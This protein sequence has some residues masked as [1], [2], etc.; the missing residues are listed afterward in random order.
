MSYQRRVFERYLTEREE[1]DLLRTVGQFAHILARRDHAWMRWMRHTGIRVAAASR[2]TCADARSALADG[3]QVVRREKGGRT[4]TIYL[5]RRARQALRDLL[6]I[7]REQGH[8]EQ[9]DAV[10]VVSRRGAPL[11]VR[12]YQSRMRY[13]AR[14]AGL[15]VTPSP[16]WLRHTLAKRVMARSTAEDPRGI[17]QAALNHASIHST[18]VY[19]MPDREQVAA[20]LDESQ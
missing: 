3:H 7:R 4:T 1:R 12:S 19:T 6:R 8:A 18:S 2:F 14:I 15:R 20:A 17:V 10:L 11:S 13:W 16:H 9:P 5:T